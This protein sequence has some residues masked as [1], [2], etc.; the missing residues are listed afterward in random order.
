MEFRF[1]AGDRRPHRPASSARFS[2]PCN[3]RAAPRAALFSGARPPL[4]PPDWE[5]AAAWPPMPPL[6]WEAAARR[7]RIIREEVER[8]LIEEGVTRELA[9]ARARLHGGLQ[10]QPFFGPGGPFAPPPPAPF[11]GPDAPFML[12][13]PVG[14]HPDAPPPMPVD[15]HPNV[16][17]PASFGPWQGFGPRRRAGFRQWKGMMTLGAERRKSLPPKPKPKHKLEQRDIEPSES[18]EVLSSETKVSGVK[19]KADVTAATTEPAK[20]KKS[21]PNWS[22][23]LCQVSATSEAGLNAHLEGKRHKAKLVK[24]GAIKV[25]DGDK[26]AL[27]ATTGNNIGAGP[28]GTPKKI[29]I[30]V[31]GVMHEVVQKS[32]FLWCERC[33]VRCEN[34]VTMA[35]HLRGKKHSE[36]NK[37]WRSINAVRME[38]KS[39]EDS[40]AKCNRKLNENG[41]IEILEEDNREGTT[42]ES[43][44]NGAIKIPVNIKKEATDMAE[45]ADENSGIELP[46]GI[47]KENTDISSEEN[48]EVPVEI[49]MEVKPEGTDVNMKNKNGPIENPAEK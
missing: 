31:D 24:C 45:V 10:P 15:M 11:F 3:R 40:A 34:N 36:L 12:P 37:V 19:R 16:P 30:F 42:S 14:M 7:E 29:C 46:V 47:K 5:A 39:K 23:A 20:L 44:E 32:N 35:S 38:N 26:S 1:R 27:E 49:L 17:R 13:M 41:P 18:S 8:R 48:K 6:E 43:N 25:T 33:S 4:Q 9:L 2:R 22:C 21:A 28:S